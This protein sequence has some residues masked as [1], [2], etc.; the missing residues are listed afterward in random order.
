MTTGRLLRKALFL[1]MILLAAMGILAWWLTQP[2]LWTPKPGLAC[3]AV[4]PAGLRQ[5]VEFLTRQARERHFARPE[6]LEQAAHSIEAQFRQA[7]GMVQSDAFT[8]EG[9][10]FRNVIAR[11]GPP[12]DPV[13]VVGAHYDV[14]RGTPGADDNASGIAGLLELA[15]LLGRNPPARAV[16]LI[17][18][19][20]EEF[21]NFGSENM[22]SWRHAARMAQAGI[23]PQVV[24][25]LEMIGY[26]DSRPDTQSY[27]LLG[28]RY[29]YPDRA[30]FIG[31]IGD[32]WSLRLVGSVKAAMQGCSEVPVY[33]INAPSFVPGVML[34]DHSS[35]WLHG[36]PALMVTDTSYLRNPHYHRSSDLPDTL[37]YA[38]M[39]QVIQGVAAVVRTLTEPGR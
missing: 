22:G 28:L 13:I 21:P 16:E 33:S 4:D 15:R 36:L 1:L 17:A 38:R 23:R 5:T 9:E 6:V 11:F 32:L 14:Q 19:T 35:Y 7:G 20:L 10:R 26:F 31:V 24:V 27:P 29:L 12:G 25:V 18:Y 30:D 8:V 34:S 3:E 2:L 39:Q 37:D